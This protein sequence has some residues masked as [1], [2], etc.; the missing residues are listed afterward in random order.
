MG[1]VNGDN[2]V[3]RDVDAIPTPSS[4]ERHAF[5]EMQVRNRNPRSGRE[6]AARVASIEPSVDEL[7]DE[8][9]QEDLASEEY[10]E[11]SIILRVARRLQVDP[12]LSLAVARVESGLSK[13]ADKNIVL[14]ARAVSPD[15]T[16][17][18]LF[19]L[20]HQTGRAQLRKLGWR[21]EYNPFDP[22]QNAHLGVS[23]LKYLV[24]MFS[25]ETVVHSDLRTVPGKEEPD[26]RR[27]AVA[28]YNAG[29][30]RV[31]KA[32]VRVLA[33]GGNPGCYEDVAMF[34]PA[35]TKRYVEKVEGFAA[36]M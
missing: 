15:G 20:T 18:G 30:G 36:E 16:S 4:H 34:L 1:A 25:K 2:D 14:N 11:T 33:H 27:L 13:A 3:H 22:R 28:A 5:V 6:T 29:I 32:Q 31:A 24:S 35:L 9:T 19:Q 17:I 10:G 26:V 21:Q 7:P 8:M 23:Y 12:A